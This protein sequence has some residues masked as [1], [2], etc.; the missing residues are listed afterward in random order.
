MLFSVVV[1]M[2]YIRQRVRGRAILLVVACIEV[3]W[4]G[5]KDLSFGDFSDILGRRNKRKEH[6]RDTQDHAL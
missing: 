2:G 3:T 5:L 4:K 1:T 6:L